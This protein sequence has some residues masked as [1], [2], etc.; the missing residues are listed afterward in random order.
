[1]GTIAVGPTSGLPCGNKKLVG[2]SAVGTT[3][4]DQGRLWC[5]QSRSRGTLGDPNRPDQS[6]HSK[7]ASNGVLHIGARA[8]LLKIRRV[9]ELRYVERFPGA[10][11]PGLA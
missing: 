11:K 7:G 9:T 2:T 8:A 10:D 1:M 6:R 4:V 3:S 5:H